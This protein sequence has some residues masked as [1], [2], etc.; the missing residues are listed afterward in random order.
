MRKGGL[1]FVVAAAIAMTA[2]NEET[3]NGQLTLAGSAPLRIAGQNGTTEFYTGPL[4]VEFAPEGGRKVKVKLKQDS[5]ETEFQVNISQ[6]DWNFTVRGSEI[7]QPVD[8]AS[9]RSVQL[10]GPVERRIGNGGPCGF[11][12]N[13]VTD[14]YWQQGTEDWTV[15]FTDAGNGSAVGTFAS[16]RNDSYLV[17]TEQL[18]CRENH[19]HEPRG[20]MG[21]WGANLSAKL[22]DI[23]PASLNFDSK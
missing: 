20:P 7:G 18:W 9:N 4:T 10:Y 8:L 1:L 3:R 19:R 5:R 21:R 17:R 2:C 16:R 23:Q 15:K 14:E 13:W 11:D 22:G 12:G 6:R